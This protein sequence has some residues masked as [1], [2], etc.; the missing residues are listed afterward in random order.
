MNFIPLIIQ[1]VA[2][3]FLAFAAFNLFGGPP[4]RPNW[5]WFGLLLWLFSLMITAVE[6]HAAR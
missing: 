6:L 4:A 1:C 5:G 2:L 3:V